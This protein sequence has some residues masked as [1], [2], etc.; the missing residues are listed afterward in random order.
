MA[1]KILTDRVSASGFLENARARL[2]GLGLSEGHAAELAPTLEAEA[3]RYV[4]ALAPGPLVASV[5]SSR[6]LAGEW[7]LY[8][9]A[10]FG[11][12]PA[13]E[14][15]AV[16][17]LGQKLK[18]PTLWHPDV[19]RNEIVEALERATGD[20][21]DV[22][23][24]VAE[25]FRSGSFTTFDGVQTDQP[26][27]PF[28]SFSRPGGGW[29]GRL[30]YHL[31]EGW[32]E[33]EVNLA[34]LPEGIDLDAAKE[35]RRLCAEMTPTVAR[36]ADLF[37]AGRWFDVRAV[38][39]VVASLRRV[40]TV[41]EPLE[42]YRF[43]VRN[44]RLLC[45]GEPKGN[46]T[47]TRVI[48]AAVGRARE[49]NRVDPG[50]YG[51]A[52]ERELEAELLAHL[53]GIREALPPDSEA[54]ADATFARALFSRMNEAFAAR[55]EV[56]GCKGAEIA[57]AV[58]GEVL[59]KKEPWHL[60]A[61]PDGA[62]P[63]CRFAVLLGHAL[64]VDV[65]IP[66]L[67]AHAR[68]PPAIAY[69]VHE[70]VT[71]LF[72]RRV[73]VECAGGQMPLPLRDG[74]AVRFDLDGPPVADGKALER[75]RQGLALFGSV[76]GHRVIRDQ[77]F[78]GHRQAL[79]LGNPDPRIIVVEG[80]WTAYADRL[81]MHSKKAAEQIR[82]VVEAEN[83]CEIPLPDGSY[84][85]LLSREI[86]PARG[87]E[88]GKLTLILG[89]ALLPNYVPELRRELGDRAKRRDMV[90]ALRLVPV[91]PLPPFAGGRA[92]EQGPQAT[93]SM[94][95]VA[96]FRAHAL[97]LAEKGGV[98]LDRA[99]FRAMAKAAG[100]PASMADAVLDR[101]T[102]DGDDGPAFLKVVGPD[103][104]TLGDAHAAARSFLEEA[105]RQ[106][107]ARSEVG[108]EQ[109]K[110]RRTRLEVSGG[111]RAGGSLCRAADT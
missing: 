83:A 73:Q 29:G 111:R 2:L 96:H 21:A 26:N 75:V 41:A 44:V 47:R 92:N 36:A 91:L 4:R 108:R 33:R 107:R 19:T 37:L 13:C 22:A 14:A 102:R 51:E 30:S 59:S 15:L 104:Y 12:S 11:K 25:M 20:G 87:H 27:E 40:R 52:L 64:L 48:V 61:D 18:A 78:T 65:V 100:V 49:K 63:G 60:W 3:L 56:V 105:G 5:M 58:R 70:P 101:W 93:L 42:A 57:A 76:V 77:I 43:A 103:L 99:A 106:K 10:R 72:S 68:R 85:R 53:A 110:R 6:E 17:A 46:Y 35:S 32:A 97:D 80:G 55:A 1:S 82:D 8:S 81:G 84:G 62:V 24:W 66:R 88:S 23:R 50:A 109:V 9:D 90:L 79:D 67:E 69:A 38:A 98:S 89:T 54:P 45:E 31:E 28:F 39:L 16:W 86:R 7:P 94:D 95:V 71:T 74:R 34:S